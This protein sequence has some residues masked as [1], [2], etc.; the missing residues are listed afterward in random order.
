MPS[1]LQANINRRHFLT[2]AGAVASG[3]IAFPYFVPSS[4]LGL[5]GSV[6]PSNRITVGL[7]GAGARGMHVI[8]E[9]FL[10]SPKAQVIAVC[11]AAKWNVKGAIATI[12]ET[13]GTKGCVG[14]A[15]FRDLL[16]DKSIDAVYIATPD[17]W[18]TPASVYAAKA[19]KDVYSEKPVT[20]TVAQ[21]QV[22]CATMKRYG[23]IYQ[24][25]TQ[26]RSSDRLRH[27]CELVR[28][29]KIGKTIGLEIV[30]PN[31][32]GVEEQNRKAG[33]P[34]IEPIPDG[35]DYDMWLGPAPWVPYRGG[36]FWDWRWRS[37][38]AAGYI[39]D[40]GTHLLDFA[41]WMLGTDGSG[42]TGVE[43]KG[44]RMAGGFWDVFSKY[45]VE[46]TYANGVKVTVKEVVQ[47]DAGLKVT[48]SE[49][50]FFYSWN[51]QS[52]AAGS[53]DYQQVKINPDEIHLYRSNNHVDNFLSCVRSRQPT[54][55]PAEVGHRSAS[56]CHL[57]VI[58][59]DVGK[60]LNWDP[61]AERFGNSDEANRMLTRS[62][63]SPWHL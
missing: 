12:D 7:I 11:D 34:R 24:S 28:N 56:L 32:R 19:G 51:S 53:A 8:R 14:Y 31:S 40:W 41:Q 1:N 47:G 15:D 29:G 30:L 18:H 38:Y 39:S 26:V 35:F 57:A 52:I 2:K 36:C 9:G 21:G 5:D 16:A 48:G 61:V 20:L 10:P 43:G 3:A 58:A 49:G 50:W 17:H 25:G 33:L 6:A 46:Y 60:R 59:M 63:R 45:E 27:A 55:S 37:D 44:E 62:M 54:I 22:L 23:R 4:A 42:P 13:Y